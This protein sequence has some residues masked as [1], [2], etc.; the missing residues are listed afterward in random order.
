MQCVSICTRS[1]KSVCHH[2]FM[3]VCGSR[4]IQYKRVGVNSILHLGCLSSA[5]CVCVCGCVNVISVCRNFC[6]C[7]FYRL[8]NDGLPTNTNTRA[9]Y[10]SL[11]SCFNNISSHQCPYM[12]S[13][14]RSGVILHFIPLHS[15]S[16]PLP[17]S[18]SIIS[19][20]STLLFLQSACFHLL[21]FLT[22]PLE[23][24]LPPKPACKNGLPGFLNYF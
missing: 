23:N 12:K 24:P 13:N 17:S 20:W 16:S 5:L 10:H 19:P 21:S 14:I 6:F 2:M 7:W 18:V 4:N 9:H 3:S 11:P 22:F 1:R 8:Q 15:S